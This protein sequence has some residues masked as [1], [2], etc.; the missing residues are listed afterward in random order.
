MGE[1]HSSSIIRPTLLA[2]GAFALMCIPVHAAE[3]P[4]DKDSAPLSFKTRSTDL[5]EALRR[6]QFAAASS[7]TDKYDWD[8]IVLEATPQLVT[9]VASDGRRLAIAQLPAKSLNADGAVTITCALTRTAARLIRDSLTEDVDVELHVSSKEI[10]LNYGKQLRIPVDTPRFPDW[11][12]VIPATDGAVQFKVSADAFLLALMRAEPDDPGD[13]RPL[14][15]LALAKGKLRLQAHPDSR[16]GITSELPIEFEGSE[17]EAQI[18]SQFVIPFA[19]LLKAR[20]SITISMRGPS[21]AI[22]FSVDSTY[23]FVVMPVAKN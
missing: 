21:E 10:T 8:V 3:K 13:D 4:T 15:T 1:P 23:R 16:R 14:V 5:C 18:N 6:T 7:K 17:R 20:D 12:R 22:L 19:R 11:R 9:F 2:L